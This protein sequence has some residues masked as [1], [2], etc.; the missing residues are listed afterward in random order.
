METLKILNR[1]GSLFSPGDILTLM[2]IW[3]RKVSQRYWQLACAQSLIYTLIVKKEELDSATM[4]FPHTLNELESIAVARKL[5]INAC[6]RLF[7]RIRSLA[8]DEAAEEVQTYLAKQ[9]GN[10]IVC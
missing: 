8:T 6:K 7:T 3:D 5:S 4:Q 10:D 9:E 1:K 2:Y